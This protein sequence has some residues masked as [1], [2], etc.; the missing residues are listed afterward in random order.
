[1]GGGKK[2]KG[3]HGEEIDPTAN[4]GYGLLRVDYTVES[5]DEQGG[6]FFLGERVL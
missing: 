5:F 1:M 4:G 6:E 3:E 2:K